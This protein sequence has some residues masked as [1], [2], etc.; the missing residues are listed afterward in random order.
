MSA[1]P[2]SEELAN[3]FSLSVIIGL[4]ATIFFFHL[5]FVCTYTN[6]SLQSQSFGRSTLTNIRNDDHV[7]LN[8]NANFFL[9]EC[10]ENPKVSQ[11]KWEPEIPFENKKKSNPYWS[12]LSFI[13]LLANYFVHGFTIH[14][15]SLI[16]SG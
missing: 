1:E 15:S 11:R 5:C 10:V 12:R 14:N 3:F 6:T 2:E 8:L 7:S 16:Y 9:T 4:R 13:F